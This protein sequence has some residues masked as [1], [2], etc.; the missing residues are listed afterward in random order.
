VCSPETC[1]QLLLEVQPLRPPPHPHLCP[2]KRLIFSQIFARNVTKSMQH[3]I[4]VGDQGGGKG[5]VRRGSVRVRCGSVECGKAH[6]V[7]RGSAGC[8]VAQQGAAWF[9]GERRGSFGA[10]GLLGPCSVRSRVRR[11][12]VGSASGSAGPSER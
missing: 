2:L 9:S 12:S 4:G 1:P 5:K 6:L 10:G 11:G 8:G 3:L 7:R